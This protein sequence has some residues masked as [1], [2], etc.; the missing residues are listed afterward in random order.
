MN[1]RTFSTG[2]LIVALLLLPAAYSDWPQWRGPL[3]NGS[4]PSAADLATEWSTEKNVVWK[5]A[6]P[7]WSAATPA[8][9][10]D[11]VFVTSAESG[12]RPSAAVQPRWRSWSRSRGRQPGR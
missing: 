8:V 3:F 5:A 12:L 6:L 9:W 1:P 11:V 2:A 10:G 7:S 4:S